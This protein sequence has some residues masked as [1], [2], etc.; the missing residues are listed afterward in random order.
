MG[1]SGDVVPDRRDLRMSHADR[2]AVVARLHIALSEG[3]LELV[4]F[5]ERL[6]GLM[7]ARTY[8]EAEAL[9]ADLPQDQAP[10]LTVRDTIELRSH[11]GNIKRTGRWAVPRRI[12]VR[13][14][15]GSV[16]LDMR[17]AIFTHQFIEIDL[18]AQAGS[19]VVVL[20]KGATADIDDVSASAGSATSR[21]PPTPEPGGYSPHLVFTGSVAAGSLTVRYERRFWRWT[22]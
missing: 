9:L 22:W 5:E 15:A 7:R 3:R 2:E 14:V 18:S 20:P 21:V 19:V 1:V 10:T 6:D 17:T 8:G 11:A 16:R 13:S 12:E 4:E